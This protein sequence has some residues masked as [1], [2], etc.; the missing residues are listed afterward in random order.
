MFKNYILIIFF[1]V[2]GIQL[3]VYPTIQ[4]QTIQSITD[5]PGGG[6]STSL[7]NDES[8]P[9]TILYVMAGLVVFG[10][11]VYKFILEEPAK[12]DQ[13]EEKPENDEKATSQLQKI[14]SFNKDVMIAKEK[15][16]VDIHI[17]FTKNK[18]APGDN[19]I[20]MGLSFNF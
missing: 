3:T 10:V 6:G 4:A 2:I 11:L 15:I 17:G 16:P 7:N 5:V 19:S 8:N 13:P 9:N 14:K 12:E 18:F 20:V 1:L